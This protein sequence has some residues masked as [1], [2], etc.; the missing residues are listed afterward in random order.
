MY[1][2]RSLATSDGV[3]ESSFISGAVADREDTM[4]EE[5]D[6]HDMTLVFDKQIMRISRSSPKPSS[7]IGMPT[8]RNSPVIEALQ[9]LQTNPKVQV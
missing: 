7:E 1:N 8:E 5:N 9:L 2:C 6:N 4:E 3:T